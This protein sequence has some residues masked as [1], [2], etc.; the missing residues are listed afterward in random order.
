MIRKKRERD[1]SLTYLEPLGDYTLIVNDVIVGTVGSIKLYEYDDMGSLMYGPQGKIALSD[2]NWRER[3]ATK[4]GWQN[5]LHYLGEKINYN[6]REALNDL[7]NNKET[8]PI[9]LFDKEHNTKYAG[10]QLIDLSNQV[11][12]VEYEFANTKPSKHLSMYSALMNNKL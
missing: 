8:N 3:T 6:L 2:V 10:L 4:M 5:H 11:Y 12:T 9:D 7:M 1:S